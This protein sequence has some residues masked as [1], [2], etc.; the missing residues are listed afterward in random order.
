MQALKPYS[1]VFSGE[2]AILCCPKQNGTE[3]SDDRERGY[4][5]PYHRKAFDGT[6]DV[7]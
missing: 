5:V 4:K 3:N 1:V 7:K 2:F 6:E